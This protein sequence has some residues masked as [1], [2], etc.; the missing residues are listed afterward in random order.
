[1]DRLASDAA[2]S[3]RQRIARDIHDSVIQPYI[4]LELGIAAACQKIARGDTD[5]TND[6]ERLLKMVQTGVADLR[7]Y[8]GE[9][10]DASGHGDSL[11]AAVRRF[12]AKFAEASGIEVQIEGASDIRVND[13]LAAEVFQMVVEGLSNIRRHTPALRATVGLECSHGHL[14]LWIENDGANEE[15]NYERTTVNKTVN[16]RAHKDVKTNNKKIA[17][18]VADIEVANEVPDKANH[19]EFLDKS[20][21]AKNVDE[22][23]EIADG[24]L[25]VA[26]TPRSISERATALGGQAQVE[27]REDGGAV[28]VV[29]IPL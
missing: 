15:I 3:E 20:T 9:L 21:T 5:V 17:N 4:G 25:P 24:T 18:K 1:V 7:H 26:F 19:Q 10:K 8:M 28:V 11:V 29:D 23:T 2:D 27:L 6:L 22:M 14:I 12:A 13:R 16:K